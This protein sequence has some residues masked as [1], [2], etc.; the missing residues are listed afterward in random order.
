[1]SIKYVVTVCSE[2]TDELKYE[3]WKRKWGEYMKN[4]INLQVVY[5]LNKRKTNLFDIRY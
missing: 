4:R 1:M 2:N 5:V 3:K